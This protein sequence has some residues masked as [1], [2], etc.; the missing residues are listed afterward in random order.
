M[1]NRIK[2]TKG[3]FGTLAHLE[4]LAEVIDRQGL[5]KP[6]IFRDR[7]YQMRPHADGLGMVPGG[8]SHWTDGSAVEHSHGLAFVVRDRSWVPINLL[9]LKTNWQTDSTQ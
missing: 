4:N 2:D 6:F 7:R 1:T 5:I 3:N 8:I 9:H